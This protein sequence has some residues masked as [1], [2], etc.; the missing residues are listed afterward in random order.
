VP[1]REAPRGGWIQTFVLHRGG[2]FLSDQKISRHALHE[3]SERQDLLAKVLEHR[4]LPLANH[5]LQGTGKHSWGGANSESDRGIWFGRRIQGTTGDRMRCPKRTCACLSPGSADSGPSWGG[6]ARTFSPLRTLPDKAVR[7]YR[8]R[9]EGHFYCAAI[10]G[11]RSD[12][13]KSAGAAG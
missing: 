10:E 9:R 8:V 4:L 7:W 6:R 12:R 13:Q 3:K 5:P 1:F 11:L 2:L